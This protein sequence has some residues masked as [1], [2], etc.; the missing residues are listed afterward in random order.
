[1]PPNFRSVIYNLLKKIWLKIFLNQKIFWLK[2]NA[3]KF[4]NEIDKWPWISANIKNN[5]NEKQIVPKNK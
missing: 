1:M 2:T 4:K 3:E 5:N